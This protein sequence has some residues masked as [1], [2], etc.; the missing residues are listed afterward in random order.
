[1]IKSRYIIVFLLAIVWA[2]G[3]N[4]SETQKETDPLALGKKLYKT[5]CSI[6][7]GDD[8]RKGLSGAKLIPESTLDMKQRIMLI[9]KGKGNM[10]PY[11]GILSKEEIEA[12]AAYTMTLK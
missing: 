7:H 10:M 12:V 11:A 6:C 9:T 5:Q 8:G 2:C 3:G 1:M 4:Q